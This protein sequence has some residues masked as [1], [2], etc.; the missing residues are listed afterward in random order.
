MIV[1][2]RGKAVL[3]SLVVALIGAP[4]MSQA[5]FPTHVVLD[6][7]TFSADTY[8][9]LQR[10]AD[11]VS[12]AVDD[13]IPG[14]MSEFVYGDILCYQIQP[15][16]TAALIAIHAPI[17]ISANYKLPYEPKDVIPGHTRIAL[18][19]A[20]VNVGQ[21]V[22][23][24]AHEIAHVK[25]GVRLDNYLIETLATAASH[26][27]L[28]DMQMTPY[29]QTEFN[30][31]MGQLPSQVL[32]EYRVLDFGALRR[33]WQ[34]SIHGQG[35]RIDDRPFQTLGAALIRSQN[36]NWRQLLGVAFLNSNCPLNNPPMNITVC[37]PDIARM[38]SIAPILN[39]LGYNLAL[40]EGR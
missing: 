14:K 8:V 40:P 25:M 38:K 4:C 13:L 18:S 16:N 5:V 11:L 26:Q 7:E 39:S 9:S 34:T 15:T 23:Q 31:E 21:F 2:L 28:I 37:P 36:V 27:V 32:D 12:H 17:T 19:Y 20:G 6:H 22:Y 30:I 3:A 24:L 10:A 35:L 33:Y 1:R 29:L